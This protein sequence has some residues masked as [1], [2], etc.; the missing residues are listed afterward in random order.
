MIN[1]PTTTT[2]QNVALLSA[3]HRLMGVGSVERPELSGPAGA[4]LAASREARA[5][6][7][8]EPSKRHSRDR[9]G[10]RRSKLVRLARIELAASCSAGKRCYFD[11]RRAV[12]TSMQRV[13]E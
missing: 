4:A 10:P 11:L 2:T 12:T 1:T 3:Y 6:V 7:R 8:R 5:G 13:R 9:N